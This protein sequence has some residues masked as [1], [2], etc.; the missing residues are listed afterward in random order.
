MSTHPDPGN[1]RQIIE[2]AIHRNFPN[3]VPAGLGLGATF[4]SEQSSAEPQ[5]QA[6]TQP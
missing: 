1:R 3:G 5:P 4:A 2:A 6:S